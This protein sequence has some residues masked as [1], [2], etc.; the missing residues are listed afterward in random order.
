MSGLDT[1]AGM[2]I[3][4]QR[5]GDEAVGRVQGYRGRIEEALH[6]IV[7][8]FVILSTCNR[9]EV[10]MDARDS[11]AAYKAIVGVLPSEVSVH[12]ETDSGASVARHLMEVAAGLDS[13]ILG[14]HEVLGQ[15]RRS[16][17]EYRQRGYTTPL[18][19][20]VFH[21]ALVAGRRAR[22]ET[23]IGRGRVGYPEV[24]VDIASERLGGLDDMTIV[25]IGAGHAGRSIL[26]SLCS[27]FKPRD[28]LVYNRTLEKAVEASRMC[29]GSAYTL[30]DIRSMPSVDVLFVAVTGFRVP[31]HVASKARLVVDLS[32][33]PA[34][35]PLP[36]VVGFQEITR[37][38]GERLEERRRW[39]PHVQRIIDEEMEVLERILGET[40]G[41][42]A[43]RI[44]M[45]YAYS[46][47]DREIALTL[48]GSNGNGV[49]RDA[50][51]TAFESY[52]RKVLH[53]LLSAL[54]KA[55][56]EGREDVVDLVMIEYAR[57]V[58]RDV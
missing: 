8:G 42:D 29:G 22:S 20:Q 17:L 23:G 21:R 48:R 10:Y 2:F 33:P 50:L 26:L 3:R 34:V 54:R 6:N 56:R 46:L 12:V 9:F 57:R 38:A 52:T 4:R 13:A 35:A 44:I 18:L 32:N 28:V 37:V 47:I 31:E 7:D 43:A 15:V 36:H 40:R 58:E 30:N 24:A 41:D 25:V 55:S 5:A 1:L 11:E 27:S 19:D 39:V 16:W 49:D 45:R 51:R 14:E 53:P